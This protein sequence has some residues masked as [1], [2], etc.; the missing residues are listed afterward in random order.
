MPSKPVTE[1]S[2]NKEKEKHGYLVSIGL[3][4]SFQLNDLLL[5]LQHLGLSFLSFQE[6]LIK[7]ESKTISADDSRKKKSSKQFSKMF[8]Y[9]SV[10]F[11]C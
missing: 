5:S 7:L 10:V 11:F 8:E 3:K 9:C 2:Q 4:F 6:L 1:I